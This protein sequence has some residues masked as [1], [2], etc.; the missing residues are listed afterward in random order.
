MEERKKML[1]E[2][3]RR[4]IEEAEELEREKEEMEREKER[5]SYRRKRAPLPEFREDSSECILDAVDE[6]APQLVKIFFHYFFF[7]LNRIT[8]IP[9]IK[10]KYK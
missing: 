4:E 1:E 10:L 6:P 2:K 7:S 5:K 8:L 3:K 9:C